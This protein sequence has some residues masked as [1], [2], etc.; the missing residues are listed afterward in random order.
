[1]S[2]SKQKTET[3][4][5]R[6]AAPIS[7]HPAFTALVMVWFAALFGLGSLVMPP[8]L[9]EHAVALTGIDALVP[10]MAPPLGFT[11][12]IL[13][14]LAA[15]IIGGIG[16]MALARKIAAAQ[17]SERQQ[18]SAV[19][20]RLRSADR[21]PDAPARRPISAL[22]ELGENRLPE[23]RSEEEGAADDLARFAAEAG[24]T[25]WTGRRRTFGKLAEPV[26][27]NMLGDAP[28]P[29][30]PDGEETAPPADEVQVSVQNDEID[31]LQASHPDT[32]DSTAENAD[33][34]AQEWS[35]APLT[36][37][38]IAEAEVEVDA[39]VD[40]GTQ[41]TLKA[42]IAAASLS[43]DAPTLPEGPDDTS[44][45]EQAPDYAAG[46]EP[47][48]T[49][50]NAAIRESSLGELGVTELVERLAYAMQSRQ[51]SAIV[52][53]DTEQSYDAANVERRIVWNDGTIADRHAGDIANP[54]A[55]Q[56][57]SYLSIPAALHPVS[58][59]D[60]DEDAEDEDLG[61]SSLSLGALSSYDASDFTQ[62]EEGDDEIEQEGEAYSSLLNLNL[63]IARLATEEDE[64]D[65]SDD[66]AHS[67]DDVRDGNAGVGAQEEAQMRHFDAPQSGPDDSKNDSDPTDQALREALARLQR[68]SGAA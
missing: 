25:E 21:H 49:H 48:P 56:P 33:E 9:A 54:P 67:W 63:G 27:E 61:L 15:A 47:D 16:G 1:M 58:F 29:D 64:N 12:R 57:E 13:I 5:P 2:Y 60:E 68:Y 45:L 32:G 34:P 3:A 42:D 35:D 31:W 62:D 52:G 6:K 41:V 53:G 8:A 66:A 39:E 17:Q 46:G 23:Y 26:P 40:E 43:L 50:D 59:E 28:L 44:G 19:E 10:A 37:F 36:A 38:D 20:P 7:A 24:L 22:E 14:A 11:A 65:E 51:Q 4:G 30:G 18:T 55:D